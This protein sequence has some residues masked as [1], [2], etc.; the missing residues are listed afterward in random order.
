[1]AM[2]LAPQLQVL[3]QYAGCTFMMPLSLDLYPVVV[4]QPQRFYRVVLTNC[5]PTLPAQ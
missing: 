2:I 4:G 1:M 3:R 5:V